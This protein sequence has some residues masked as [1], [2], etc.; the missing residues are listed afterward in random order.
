MSQ[1]MNKLSKTSTTSIVALA[2]VFGF[3]AFAIICLFKSP[4]DK[5]IAMI[6]VGAFSGLMGSLSN[7]YFNKKT[8]GTED[9]SDKTSTPS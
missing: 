8:N 2:L 4:A 1:F 9:D 5:D 6:I 7:Y 3:F